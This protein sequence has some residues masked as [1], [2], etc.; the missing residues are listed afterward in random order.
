MSERHSTPAP[1]A[2]SHCLSASTPIVACCLFVLPE[3]LGH[4][5]LVTCSHTSSSKRAKTERLVADQ[6]RQWDTHT[7]PP[8]PT[9]T[10]GVYAV[11]HRCG[12][13]IGVRNFMCLHAAAGGRAEV[14]GNF[15]N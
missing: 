5:S 11:V 14:G 8:T 9:L 13:S 3:Q 6:R 2:V 15:E 7:R 10:T 4:S 1:L 12:W